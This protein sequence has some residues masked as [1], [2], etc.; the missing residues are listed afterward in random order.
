MTY[1]ITGA[2]GNTGKPLA[3][4]L[5]DAGKSVR[6]ITRDAAKAQDLVDKGAV[7]VLGS[8]TDPAVLNAAFAGATAVY[9]MIPPNGSAPDFRAYQAAAAQAAAEALQANRVPYAVTLSSVGAHLPEGAGV[10]QGLQIMEST[11]NALSETHVLHLRPGYFMENLLGQIGGIKAQGALAAAVNAD[12]P[13]R[14]IATQDIAAYAAQRLLALD[15]SGTGNFQH[16]IGPG[17]VSY[18]E[19]T[20]LIGEAIGRSD[21]AF[22]QVSPADFHNFITNVWGAS[23]NFADNMVEFTKALNDGRIEEKARL[24]AL[25]APTTIQEFLASTFRYVYSL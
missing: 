11:L 10:V 7:L 24:D 19:V 14:M 8:S 9:F 23:T 6:I 3:H 16:L 20:G 17:D 18:S 12:K 2:T 5:L 21:L 4:A 25:H 13:F 15:W 1:V 22:Y